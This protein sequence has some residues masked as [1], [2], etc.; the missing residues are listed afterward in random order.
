MKSKI[1]VK[2]SFCRKI[3]S[4]WRVPIVQQTNATARVEVTA[5]MPNIVRRVVR[6]IATHR[7]HQMVGVVTQVAW[8][9]VLMIIPKSVLPAESSRLVP[10]QI[11]NA[12]RNARKGLMQ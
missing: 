4:H 8:E 6:I 10:I 3:S 7:A 9:D 2:I 1:T 11:S 12:L 5:G